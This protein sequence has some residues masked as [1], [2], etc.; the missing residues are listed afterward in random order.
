MADDGASNQDV[1]ELSGDK[2][3]HC[4]YPGLEAHSPCKKKQ[5]VVPNLGLGK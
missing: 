3:S 4:D 1:L 5:E 2:K